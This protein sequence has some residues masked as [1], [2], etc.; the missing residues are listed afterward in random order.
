METPEKPAR[1]SPWRSPGSPGGSCSGSTLETT[2][3]L[4]KAGPALA[5]SVSS[6]SE[7]G[8]ER[9][10][11]YERD[12]FL[13]P[14]RSRQAVRKVA[15][16]LSRSLSRLSHHNEPRHSMLAERK[17]GRYLVLECVDGLEAICPGRADDGPLVTYLQAKLD[18][19]SAEL[20]Q[21]SA[22]MGVLKTKANLQSVG[23]LQSAEV[24]GRNTQIEALHQALVQKSA[25]VAQKDA[26]IRHLEVELC[27]KTGPRCDNSVDLVALQ[28]DA[29]RVA[30]SLAEQ[31]AETSR[32]RAQASTA[33]TRCT[34]MEV[35]L[36]RRS[37]ELASR[38]SLVKVLEAQRDEKTAAL[39]EFEA[40]LVDSKGEMERAKAVIEQ[41]DLHLV[42]LQ[43]ENKRLHDLTTEQESRIHHLLRE[44]EGGKREVSATQPEVQARDLQIK[45]LQSMVKDLLSEIQGLRIAAVGQDSTIHALKRAAEGKQRELEAA[46]AEAEARDRQISQLQAEVRG[47]YDTMTEKVCRIHLLDRE[48]ELLKCQALE[49]EQLREL[50]GEKTAVIAVREKQLASMTAKILERRRACVATKRLQLEDMQRQVLDRGASEA[51]LAAAQPEPWPASLQLPLGSVAEDCSI[52]RLREELAAEIASKEMEK[53]RSEAEVEGGPASL[54]RL[55]A[56]LSERD[57]ELRGRKVEIDRLSAMVTVWMAATN[58]RDEELASVQEALAGQHGELQGR[59]DATELE[60]I[61]AR[62][63]TAASRREAI[64]KGVAI[65]QQE[66]SAAAHVE[67]ARGAAASPEAVCGAEGRGVPPPGALEEERGQVPPATVEG[68]DARWASLTVGALL[69][70]QHDAPSGTAHLAR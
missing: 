46:Q 49:L 37:S 29:A 62:A 10:N 67:A 16:N 52:A 56:S 23:A 3:G 66:G 5:D 31:E 8:D 58:E 14:A 48:V 13:T 47:M 41:Q 64:E 42:Q 50:V 40:Q 38:D 12:H 36:A 33:A 43:S 25:E 22:K 55:R 4:V 18:E 30:A 61:Q 35:V 69:R 19:K 57:A 65:A 9:S 27:T 15:R 44:V 1:G 63:A 11:L 24:A 39:A 54:E 60:L 26:R 21:L 20:A 32:F 45:E 68:L 28:R 17:S 70:A 6:L 59:L 53:S 2:T 34:E 7:L 51:G